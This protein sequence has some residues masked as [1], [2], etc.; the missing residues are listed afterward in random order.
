MPST[1]TRGHGHSDADLPAEAEPQ[2]VA[3]GPAWLQ[4]GRVQDHDSESAGGHTYRAARRNIDG[5]G[6]LRAPRT[7]PAHRTAD[8]ADPQ[9]R[10][11]RVPQSVRRGAGVEDLEVRGG[12]AGPHGRDD[13]G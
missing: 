8:D 1:R 12:G 3:H 11:V 5:P 4:R 6:R 9:I 10:G 13:P 2:V 7:G